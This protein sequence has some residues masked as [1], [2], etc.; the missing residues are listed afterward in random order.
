MFQKGGT[1][2]P[3]L[4]AYDDRAIIPAQSVFSFDNNAMENGLR[5][6]DRLTNRNI[7]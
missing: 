5:C 6:E 2:A 7:F 4:Y 3:P 1:A